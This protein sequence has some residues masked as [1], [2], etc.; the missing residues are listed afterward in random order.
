MILS[1]GHISQTHSRSSVLTRMCRDRLEKIATT[2]GPSPS[3]KVQHSKLP[4][5]WILITLLCPS[6]LVA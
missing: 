6:G 4:T 1:S 2:R 3:T 5:V